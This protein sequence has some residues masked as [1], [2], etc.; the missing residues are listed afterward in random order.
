MTVLSHRHPWAGKWLRD[1][2]LFFQTAY[3]HH[4]DS[5]QTS[6][7]DSSQRFPDNVL[8]LTSAAKSYQNTV[9]FLHGLGNDLFFPNIGIL[10][11]LAKNNFLVMSIDLAGHGVGG[12]S[13]FSFE[14]LELQIPAAIKFL[15]HQ[16]PTTAKIHLVG[17]SFGAA[18]AAFYAS[19]NQREISSLSMIALP[20]SLSAQL[21]YLSEL[22]SPFSAHWYS[23]LKK[24]GFFGIQP[25]IGPFLRSK[26]PVRCETNSSY[27]EIAG[28]ILKQMNLLES[29]KSLN[30]PTSAIF[31]KYDYISPASNY[32]EILAAS[33]HK[34]SILPDT[35]HFLTLL[36]PTTWK[37]TADFLQS[38]G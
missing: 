11:E 32:A 6:A 28:Q 35:N 5:T 10:E 4:V 17:Y 30:V 2:G 19:Q 26:Y 14:N 7:P 18:F 8:I 24:Y 25:A 31:G 37:L 15:R 34:V 21:G 16:F 1:S 9:I 13:D 27:F 29:L 3:V 22:A 12:V 23:A 36:S 38:I 20:N 33:G